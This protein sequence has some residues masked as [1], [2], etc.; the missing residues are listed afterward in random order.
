MQRLLA[1]ARLVTLSGVG[2]SGKTRLALEVAAGS[3]RAYPDGV[4]VVELG[5]LRDPALVSSTAASALGVVTT[6]LGA[7][8]DAVT[9]RLCEYLQARKALLV[10]ENCEHLVEAAAAMVHALLANCPGVT[11]MTTSR[12]ILGLA[13]EVAWRVPPLSLPASAITDIEDLAASDAAALFCERARAAQPAFGLSQANVA[14]VAQICHRLDGIPL[15]LE[16]AAARIRVLGAHD[17]ARRLDQRFRL[18]TGGDHT[19]VPRHQTLQATMDWSYDLLPAD[20]QATLRRLAVFPGSFDLDAADAVVHGSEEIAP[21]AGEILDLLSRLID[22][23]LVGVDS[24]GVETRFRL[25]ETV[26]EYAA[27][28]SRRGRRDS[29]GPE[30]TL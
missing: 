9:E 17:L 6:G 15:A 23:S 3:L 14:A 10:L 11:I 20:E 5:P 2:G 4:W 25:L 30:A 21:A 28:E 22:K 18:L 16:L 8:S 24:Q 13:G 26:R 1:D 7:T 19:A 12:E 27:R 29:R